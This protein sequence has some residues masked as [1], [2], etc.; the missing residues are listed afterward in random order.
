V[1]ILQP[2]HFEPERTL[3]DEGHYDPMKESGMIEEKERRH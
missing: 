2:Y 3:Y 1:N